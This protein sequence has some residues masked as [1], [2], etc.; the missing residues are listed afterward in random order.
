MYELRN[1]AVNQQKNIMYI[2][3]G[4]ILSPPH[5]CRKDQ[6][7]IVSVRLQFARF[8]TLVE[9]LIEYFIQHIGYQTD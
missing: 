8:L 6:L 1:Y 5:T 3:M 4:A 7:T 2:I 9:A